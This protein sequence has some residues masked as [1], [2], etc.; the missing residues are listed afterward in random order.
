MKVRHFYIFLLILTLSFSSAKAQKYRYRLV[1]KSNGLGP[2]FFYDYK[3]LKW[4]GD[5]IAN[6]HDI[7]YGTFGVSKEEADARFFKT[8]EDEGYN[9]YYISTLK[10]FLNTSIARRVYRK[11]QRSAR[12][13]IKYKE[14]AEKA[15]NMTIDTYHYHIVRY[16]N[17]PFRRKK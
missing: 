6:Q 3:Y 17:S 14:E 12:K 10:Y 15:M 11:S 5:N 2:Y 8:L 4:P 1:E 16:R 9:S 7:D 13:T